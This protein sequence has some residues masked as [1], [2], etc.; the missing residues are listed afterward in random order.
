MNIKALTLESLLK[1][2]KGIKEVHTTRNN[3]SLSKG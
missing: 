2:S 1:P 3:V